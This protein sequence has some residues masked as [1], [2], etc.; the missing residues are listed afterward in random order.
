MQQ[1][2]FAQALQPSRVSFAQLRR[3]YR[4]MLVLVRALIGVEPNCDEYLEIWPPA[5]RAYNLLVPNTLNLPAM[6]LGMGTRKD[7]IG[8]AMYASSRAAECMYC[9]AHCCSFALRRGTPEL[10]L[11]GQGTR[12]EQAVVEVAA[13]LARVPAE[14]PQD[15]LGVLREELFTPDLEWLLWSIALMGFLNKFMDAM[16]VPLE[17]SA[18]ADV[19]R[20][21]GP[22]GWTPGKHA[23]GLG[24]DE[25]E[26]QAAD[27]QVPVDNLGLYLRVLS[28]GP[29]AMRLEQRW[30]KGI[31]VTV[32]G[33]L[34]SVAST[35]GYGFPGLANLRQRRPIIAV[36]AVLRDQLDPT[37]TSVGL[38]EKVLAGLVYAEQVQSPQLVSD[39]LALVT[40][41]A[42]GIAPDELMA[43]RRFARDQYTALPVTTY[44]TTVGAVAM[45]AKL[46][47]ASPT[48]LTT[49]DVARL[50][51]VFS[52]AQIV[53]L[54]AWLG[55]LQLLNRVYAFESAIEYLH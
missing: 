24:L 22:T 17:A 3:D 27:H 40:I 11:L 5:F 9:S 55:V 7:L 50:T 37:Q 34:G 2:T 1:A 39:L 23:W 19:Q 15:A 33:A 6:L 49:T 43:L 45:L 47:G 36:S 53:E 29:A 51:T 20:L 16:G 18:V 8:L 12:L 35:V 41:Y 14:V 31:D 42:S 54:L 48:R 25:A 26:S 52:A 38:V 21:I 10:A 32:P 4:P 44:D 30:T 13:G 46:A 28:Q